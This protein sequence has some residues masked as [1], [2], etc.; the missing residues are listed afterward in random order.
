[1][2]RNNSSIFVLLKFIFVFLIADLRAQ[3]D[4]LTLD[5]NNIVY[6]RINNKY[7]INCNTTERTLLIAPNLGS[8][9]RVSKII[10]HYG[11]NKSCY[12][13]RPNPE[14]QYWLVNNSAPR[15][16]IS[17]EICHSFNPENLKVIKGKNPNRSFLIADGSHYIWDF[18]SHFTA[19]KVIN[20]IKDYGFTHYCF[21]EDLGK[22]DFMYLRK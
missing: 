21:E 14:F 2:L 3:D 12:I 4:C 15:G 10:K 1:M 11:F 6:K 5:P 16:R 17:D 9:R 20:I 7:Y 19:S 22:T 18:E 8:A 13:G